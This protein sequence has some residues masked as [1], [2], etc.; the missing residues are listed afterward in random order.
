[1]AH[2]ISPKNQH[3]TTNIK[4]S[5]SCR[6]N[7]AFWL[8]L[9]TIG[10]KLVENKNDMV[11]LPIIENWCLGYRLNRLINEILIHQISISIQFWDTTIINATNI[12]CCEICIIFIKLYLWYKPM[13]WLMIPHIFYTFYIYS[14]FIINIIYQQYRYSISAT[15]VIR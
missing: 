5:T 7:R 14:R 11:Q 13:Q 15:I 10:T 12:K 1:M 2:S 9:V 6:T 4:I 3:P 8:T